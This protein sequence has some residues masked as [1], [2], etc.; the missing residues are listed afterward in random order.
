MN[1]LVNCGQPFNGAGFAQPFVYWTPVGGY[2]SETGLWEEGAV[3]ENQATGS[4]QPVSRTALH[5]L[6]DLGITGIKPSKAIIIYTNAPLVAF[7]DNCAGSI[8]R[9]NGLEWKV[10]DIEDFSAHG[11]IEA[12]A[13]RVD[14]Q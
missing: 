6:A 2:N 8:V 12:I 3:V 5:E 1:G 4:I 7:E 10:I 13:V 9:Y 14:N 11:H